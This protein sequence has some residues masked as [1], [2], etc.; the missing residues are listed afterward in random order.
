MISSETYGR[1]KEEIYPTY[2]LTDREFCARYRKYGYQFSFD[3][4]LPSIEYDYSVVAL[5]GRQDDGVGY[6]DAWDILKHLPRFTYLALDGVGHNLHLENP[7][8][9]EVMVKN[10][11]NLK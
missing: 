8:V 1:F 7:M 10:W 2:A 3:S 9:F 5:T 4:M 11:L 6:E